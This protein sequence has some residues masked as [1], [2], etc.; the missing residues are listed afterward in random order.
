MVND[1]DYIRVIYRKALLD[2]MECFGSFYNN[3]INNH[4]VVAKCALYSREI[5]ILFIIYTYIYMYIFLSK[6]KSRHYK[7][8]VKAGNFKRVIDIFVF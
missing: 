7:M 5:S 2:I 1:N 3:K 4:E 6:K 8:A